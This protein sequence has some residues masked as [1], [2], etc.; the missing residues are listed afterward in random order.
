MDGTERRDFKLEDGGFLALV[1]IVTLAFAWL[2][3][4]YFG[5]ILWGVVVAILFTPLYRRL[6]IRFGGRR[7]W[8]AAATLLIILLLVILPSLFVAASLVQEAANVYAQL[9]SGQIDLA[10]MFLRMHDALPHWAQQIVDRYGLTDLN[11]ARERLGGMLATGLNSIAGQALTF[12]QGALNFVA[13]LSVMLYLAYFLIR[14]GRSLN[15]QIRAFVPLRPDIRDR[16]IEH[17]VVV[18]RATMKGTVV[19][20]IVQG[21]LGGVIFWALGIQGALLWGVMMGFFSLVPAVGTAIIWAPIAGYLL[22]TGSLWEGGILVACGILVIGMVDNVL[23]PILVGSDTRMP[24]FVILIATLAG[25]E[26]FGLNGFIIGPVIAALFMAVWK[27]VG[28]TRGIKFED[29]D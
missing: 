26:L 2:M 1:L 8:A 20:A 7:N 11:A 5:A 18:V 19:V 3:T 28:E 13:S 23:R 27:S 21:V 15:N 14:D 9:R 29:E 12:G 16:L 25:L 4:P 24:D 22:L 10:R 17:F 6:T